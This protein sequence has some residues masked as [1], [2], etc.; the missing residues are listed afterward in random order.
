MA[1][2]CAARLRTIDSSAISFACGLL[3]FMD[4]M[5]TW[6]R[7]RQLVDLATGDAMRPAPG[8]VS[9]LPGCLRQRHF[10]RDL[11]EKIGEHLSR[12]LLELIVRDLE[13]FDPVEAEVAEPV[14]HLA[15]GR[16]RP[17]LPPV[18]EPQGMHG[19][20]AARLRLVDVPEPRLSLLADGS[21][22]GLETGAEALTDV[23]VRRHQRGG[24]ELR[25][26]PRRQ[27]V[28]DL[29]QRLFRRARELLVRPRAHDPGAEHQ[30]LDLL[31][32]KHQRRQLEA[33][34]ERIAHPRLALDGHSR[35]EKVADVAI[36]GPL[37]HLQRLRQ[38]PR[39]GRA[40]PPETLDDA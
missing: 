4:A 13:P 32:V 3:G 25:L 33:A 2:I 9:P 5:L 30:R 8:R 20:L 36:D 16:Q 6:S 10:R 11:R 18:R 1:S 15:P 14:P 22:Q 23:E 28:L 12:P 31:L 35:G 7:W 39:G 19:A 38:L 29:L 27:D 34:V 37:G 40:A 17:D 26:E 24:F 21:A